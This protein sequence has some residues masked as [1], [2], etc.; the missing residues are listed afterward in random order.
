MP[1]K[2]TNIGWTDDTWNPVHGCSKI[3]E[4]CRNCYAARQSQQYE[5]T[6][7]PWTVEHADENV[8]H[9]R[10]HL[11]Y[12]DDKDPMRIFVNSMSDLFHENVPF[13]YIH[14]IFDV[15]ERNPQHAFQA[16]TK[17]GTEN[18][19]MLEW[20]RQY[21]RWPENLWM[22]VSVETGRRSYRIEHLRAT[23]A[24]T[25]W[26]SFEPLVDRVGE[27]DLQGVDWVVIG[28]ESGPDYREMPHAWAREIRDAARD[29]DLP[30]YFKQSAARYNETGRALV[31]ENL[32]RTVLRELPP[33]PDQLADSRPDLL[34]KVVDDE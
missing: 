8:M 19:R 18:N 29:H 6:T 33:L 24:A 34:E 23:A 21:A 31:E 11:E 28:G 17:H 3:S 2:D 32:T 25:K 15:I 12:P 5:H 27:P 16:L 14:D 9:Q 26:V 20:D 4:G 7:K 30:V 13:D 1:T 22:G 10:H